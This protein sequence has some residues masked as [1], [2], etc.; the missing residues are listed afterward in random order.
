MTI[1]INDDS[2]VV[3]GILSRY[4]SD[5]G[6]TVLRGA[7]G[8]EAI[9]QTYRHCPDLI[10]MDVEMPLLQGYQACRILKSRRGVRDIPIIMHTSL[11]EDKDQ[12][13][14]LSS[15]ANAFITKDF[16]NL[17]QLK[18]TIGNLM[19]Y[20]DINRELVLE[21]SKT[22]TRDRIFEMLGST[23]DTQLFQTTIQNQLGEVA[24][25]SMDSLEDT[26]SEMIRVLSR[27]C[28]SHIAVLMLDYK[29]R[30]FS[31]LYPSGEIFRSDMET[32]LKTCKNDFYGNFPHLDLEKMQEILCGDEKRTDFDKVRIDNKRISSY[33]HFPL[34]GK[35][36]MVVASL[37][38]GSMK[39]NYY[40]DI[41]NQNVTTFTESAGLLL[42]NALLFREVNEIKDRIRHVFTKFVP[43]EIIDD[44]IERQSDADLMVGE[45]R[46]IVVLFSDIRSFTTITETNPPEAVVRFLNRYFDT[47]VAIIKKHGGN[48][49]KFIGDAIFAIFGAPVSYED[50]AFRAASAALEMIKALPYIDIKDLEI[51]GG[52]LHI[53]IGL[54][55]GSAIIGNIGSSTKFDYTAIGDTVNIAARL[56][57]LTKFYKREILLTEAMKKKI[58]EKFVMREV[59][60]AKVKGK[61]IATGLYALELDPETI[62]PEYIKEHNKAMKLFKMGNFQSALDYFTRLK[63]TVP[64]DPVP[65]IYIARCREYIKNPPADWD[66]SISL[67][68]K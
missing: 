63:E 48:V 14:A 13:W 35:G 31:Y 27:V 61:D 24:R 12:F 3:A 46:E 22:L 20:A 5:E 33:A 16:D 8:V 1:L 41:I 47:Q 36:G 51:P 56:E 60:F 28:E 17:E 30:G 52:A 49:D 50:N 57:S 66:G 4:L 54:H 37:H 42:E 55:E 62:T 43:E 15:G 53:G 64:A 45:K 10:I 32:F 65:D 26:I 44:L 9:E 67:D 18:T 6:Y 7:N 25:G 34:F 40:S 39:N 38:L 58:E 19:G 29:N 2:E 59:D 21:E 11:S 23:F 68:F